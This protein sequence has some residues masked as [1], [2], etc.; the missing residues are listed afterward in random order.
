MCF[1][2]SGGIGRLLAAQRHGASVGAECALGQAASLIAVK[3]SK[4]V[5]IYSFFN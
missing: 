4:M 1:F 2:A 5:V 3:G